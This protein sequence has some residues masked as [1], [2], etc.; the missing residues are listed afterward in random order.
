MLS[1]AI[2]EETRFGSLQQ[3][4]PS[5]LKRMVSGLEALDRQEL[6]L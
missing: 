3:I 6:R 2:L 4:L 5:G 1:W